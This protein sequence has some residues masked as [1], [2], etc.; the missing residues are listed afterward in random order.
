MSQQICANIETKCHASLIHFI[1]HKILLPTMSLIQAEKRHDKLKTLL[2]IFI[3][4]YSDE[5]N[6]SNTAMGYSS[7]KH[8]LHTINYALPSTISCRSTVNGTLK[9]R[10]CLPEYATDTHTHTCISIWYTSICVRLIFEKIVHFSIHIGQN[11]MHIVARSL[12]TITRAIKKCNNR[13]LFTEGPKKHLYNYHSTFSRKILINCKLVM[14]YCQI[15][16]FDNA[17]FKLLVGD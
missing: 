5:Q 2:I 12:S 1:C 15:Q 10:S 9:S 6:E 3:V 7:I 4:V 13:K 17:I 8:Y 14:T 11:Q 16:K